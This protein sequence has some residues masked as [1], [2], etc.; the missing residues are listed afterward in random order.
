[1]KQVSRDTGYKMSAIGLQGENSENNSLFLREKTKDGVTCSESCDLALSL[2]GHRGADTER[3]L[4]PGQL[5]EVS[6][7]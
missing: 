6:V 4:M 2:P 3:E 5:Y 7:I 1:M